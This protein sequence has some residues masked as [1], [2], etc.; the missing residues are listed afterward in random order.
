MTTKTIR[1][2]V[3][4]ETDE[5]LQKTLKEERLDKSAATRRILELG[6]SEW[7]KEKAIDAL[8]KGKATL[9]KAAEIA[10]LSIYEMIELVKEKN[11]DYIHITPK[12]IK[13]ESILFDLTN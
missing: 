1:T 3:P 4:K 6:I 8:K 10:D 2:R 9:A 13:E 12:D 11:I 7:R 5:F